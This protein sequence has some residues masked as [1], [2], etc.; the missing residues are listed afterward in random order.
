[1]C[2]KKVVDPCANKNCG[3]GEV[4]FQGN[5]VVVDPCATVQCQPFHECQNGQCIPLDSCADIACPGTQVCKDGKC[6]DS[7]S[8]RRCSTNVDCKLGDYDICIGTFCMLNHPCKAN[9]ECYGNGYCSN[10]ICKRLQ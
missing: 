7:N 8:A 2:I 6:E 4:C 9:Y 10:K 3:A 1:M 5:C